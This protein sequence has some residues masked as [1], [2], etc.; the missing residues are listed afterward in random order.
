[1]LAG[2]QVDQPFVCKLAHLRCT[3]RKDPYLLPSDDIDGKENN[4]RVD[5][6]ANSSSSLSTVAPSTASASA[7]P[8]SSAVSA[9]RKRSSKDD[10][11]DLASVLDVE[12]IS[13]TPRNGFQ[14]EPS[15]GIESVNSNAMDDVDAGIPRMRLTPLEL[16]RV[17]RSLA[18]ISWPLKSIRSLHAST[19]EG[20]SE[21]DMA[22]QLVKLK[23][24]VKEMKLKIQNAIQQ[25][26]REKDEARDLEEASARSLSQS[27][28][29]KKRR[30]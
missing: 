27:Q 13:S 6:L 25:A 7:V 1:M 3:A 26:E 11:Q 23:S 17:L 19:S 4:Q 16:D 9:K 12:A 2:L 21:A 14:N 15:N 20:L 5:D 29:K 24:A 28:P 30:L 18:S 8:S 22:K 10:D